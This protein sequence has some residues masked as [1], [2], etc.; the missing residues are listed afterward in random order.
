VVDVRATTSFVDSY[1]F[2]V[3]WGRTKTDIVE[4]ALDAAKGVYDNLLG[5]V[6]NKV[7]FDVLNRYEGYRGNY[8]YRQYYAQYGYAE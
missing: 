1:G 5:V 7:D 2:V 6:L 3:E 8:Y 4:H